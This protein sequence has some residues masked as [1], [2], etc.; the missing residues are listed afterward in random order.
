MASITQTIPNYTSG[1]SEQ[2]DH[3]KNP[4]QV[5]DALNV[6][7]EVTTGLVKRPGSKY[8]K[9]L[10]SGDAPTDKEVTWFHYYRDQNEHYLGQ[11]TKSTEPRP[12]A[13]TPEIKMWDIK[14]G[15]PDNCNHIKN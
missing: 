10:D 4:G 2:P 14:T 8:I 5:S 15:T 7:P 1:L 9:T 12:T 11:I 6:V 3:L 13:Y